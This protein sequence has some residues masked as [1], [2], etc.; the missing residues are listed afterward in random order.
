MESL[1]YIGKNEEDNSMALY[2]SGTYISPAT[3]TDEYSWNSIK[4]KNRTDRA[5]LRLVM[6]KR[7]LLTKM[8]L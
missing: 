6:T 2:W 3:Y 5:Y 4:D 8:A 1:K 7:H